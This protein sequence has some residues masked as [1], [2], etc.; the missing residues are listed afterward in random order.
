[1]RA[2]IVSR[3]PLS[4][5][6]EK[7]DLEKYLVVGK[8]ENQENISEQLK[9]K[10]D[11]YEALIGAIY[12]DSDDIATVEKFILSTLA[13]VIEDACVQDESCDFKSKIN[14]YCSK[15]NKKFVFKLENQDGPPHNPMFH[16]QLI[17]GE[18]VAG[19][20]SGHTKRDAQ[21]HACAE[22]IKKLKIK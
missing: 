15:T 8:G 17:I 19:V 13:E 1:R 20:G 9:I 10:S 18:S 21:Q 6:V 2:N 5:V 11:I 7:F 14:E 12:Y 3:Q 22:A 4:D 16:Y